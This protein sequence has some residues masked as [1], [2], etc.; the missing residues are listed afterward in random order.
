MRAS[1]CCRRRRSRASAMPPARPCRCSCATAPSISPSCRTSS[2]RWSTNAETQSSL[3]AGDRTLSR[4]RSAIHRRGRPGEDPDAGTDAQS[5]VRCAGRLSRRQLCRSVQQV[6]P[7]LP[8]L[9]AGGFAVPPADAGHQSPD[10]AQQQRRHDSAR[11][12]GDDQ[13]HGRVAADQSLQ[14]LS[15]GDDHRRCRRAASRP[16]RR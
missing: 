1:W 10:R 4:D 13:A 7:H 16:G 9:R 12:A 11:H 3:Q 6:R 2:R 8:D 5:G 15:V 14:S